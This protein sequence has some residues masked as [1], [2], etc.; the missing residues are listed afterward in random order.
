M[1]NYL[2]TTN[3]KVSWFKQIYDTDKLI[4]KPPYQRNPVWLDR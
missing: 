4:M 1:K 3:Y 2:T